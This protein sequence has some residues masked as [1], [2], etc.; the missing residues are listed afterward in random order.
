MLR[1]L[2]PRTVLMRVLLGGARGPRLSRPA[3]RRSRKRSANYTFRVVKGDAG[4]Y[5]GV[6]DAVQ[7][8]YLPVS[9]DARARQRIHAWWWP[10]ADPKAPVDLLPARRRAGI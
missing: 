2:W 5:S 10:D 6:P 9:A 7:D 4:W 8:V 1:Y 3:A